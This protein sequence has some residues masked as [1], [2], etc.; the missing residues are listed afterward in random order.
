[1]NGGDSIVPYPWTKMASKDSEE[2]EEEEEEEEKRRRWYA[3]GDYLI[4]MLDRVKT[5]THSQSSLC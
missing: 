2:E 4:K 1:M 3:D 5:L